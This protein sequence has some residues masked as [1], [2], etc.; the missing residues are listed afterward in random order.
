MIC[1][2]AINY[3]I[4]NP[5][6]AI[7]NKK[8]ELK[9]SAGIILSSG[10][11]EGIHMNQTM[12]NEGKISSIKINNVLYTLDNSHILCVYMDPLQNHLTTAGFKK[13][14]K[15]QTYKVNPQKNGG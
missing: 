8:V 6:I 5:N 15:S 4:G 1:Y 14:K 9:D 7:L 3:L 2:N 11:I 13:R 12:G 10:R